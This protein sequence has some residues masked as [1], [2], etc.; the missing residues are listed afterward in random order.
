[1]AERMARDGNGK[2]DAAILTAH[3]VANDVRSARDK[4]TDA[5]VIDASREA[6]RSSMK[7]LNGGP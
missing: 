5:R 1:M 7:L 2:V 3:V 4:A 6:I